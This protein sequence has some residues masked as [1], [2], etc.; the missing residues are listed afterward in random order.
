VGG[1]KGQ[2]QLR[3]ILCREAPPTRRGASIV[4]I[5]EA[6]GGGVI[7]NEIS[8]IQRRSL[9]FAWALNSGRSIEETVTMTFVSFVLIQFF[10]AYNFRSDRNSVL[11]RPLSN[12][13]LNLAILWEL[14]LLALII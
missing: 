5:D 12:R 8:G 2:I 1:V 4:N 3:L 13:W 7:I 11:D 6:M 9:L 10:K 14:V